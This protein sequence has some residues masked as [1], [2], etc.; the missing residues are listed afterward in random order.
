MMTSLSTL[1]LISLSHGSLAA[2]L[3]SVE[4]LPLIGLLLARRCGALA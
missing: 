4:L 1:D 2:E 3:I